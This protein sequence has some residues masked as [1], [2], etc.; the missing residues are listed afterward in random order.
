ME[1]SPEFVYICY[2]LEHCKD[3]VL[4]LK[5]SVYSLV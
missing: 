2:P 3:G 4:N 1:M 5:E